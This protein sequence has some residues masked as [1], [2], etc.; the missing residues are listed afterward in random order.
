GYR[1]RYPPVPTA[2]GL[3]LVLVGLAFLARTA[4]RN[5]DWIDNGALFRSAGKIVPSS[6][7]IR[8]YL[9][10]VAQSER[11]WDQARSNYEAA[12]L[13]YPGYVQTD[14]SL[15]VTLGDVYFN[16]GNLEKAAESLERAIPLAPS[17]AEAHY[18]LGLVYARL[19]RYRESEPMVR[20]ALA[21][22]PEFPE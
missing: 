11:D 8:A 10:R 14:A 16:L 21:L 3:L 15:N 2:A 13:I 18:N 12:T 7:K 19:A 4:W 9:G 22:R 6:A 17:S 5:P 1:L 20:K